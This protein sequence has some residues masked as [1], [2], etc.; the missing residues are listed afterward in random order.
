MTCTHW[1]SAVQVDERLM[2]K[3]RR[4]KERAAS[5]SRN[6]SLYAHAL[7]AVTARRAQC[8]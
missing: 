7:G 4:L 1:H 8:C 2:T 5:P 6:G 3:Q